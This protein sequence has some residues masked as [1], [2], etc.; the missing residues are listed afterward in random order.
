MKKNIVITGASS[1]LGKA[2]A[3]EYLKL[4]HQVFGCGR[5][6]K[7]SIGAMHYSSVDLANSAQV[8]AWLTEVIYVNGRIDLC[9][10]CA[11][12]LSFGKM[13]WE[14][15]ADETRSMIQ[16][17]VIGLINLMR[18]VIPQMQQQGYGRFITMASNPAGYPL[19]GL[20]LYAM[21]KTAVEKIIKVVGEELPAQVIAVALYPGLINTPMLQKSIGTDAAEV[22]Q[23]PEQWAQ[24]AGEAIINISE[25]YQG[26]HIGLE[27][28]LG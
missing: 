15:D 23:R 26:Q 11:G 8:S 25:K 5:T 6:D 2:L 13:F 21:C 17:N 12:S 10:N 28:L 4:G 20:G 24:E 1:G 9:V 19:Q 7:K 27:E 18:L 16:I 3:R 22:Y 14:Y